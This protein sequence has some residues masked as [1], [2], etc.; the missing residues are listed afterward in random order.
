MNL[1]IIIVGSNDHI[2]TICP[3]EDENTK[4]IHFAHVYESHYF[5]LDVKDSSTPNKEYECL[6]YKEES[7]KFHKWARQNAVKMG[8]VSYDNQE[9]SDSGDNDE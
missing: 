2:E 9:S 7:R 6:L 3:N 8:K 5:P 4:T 1:K